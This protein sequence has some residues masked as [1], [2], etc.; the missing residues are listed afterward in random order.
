MGVDQR[1]MYFDPKIQGLYSLL[2]LDEVDDQPDRGFMYYRESGL[3]IV[4]YGPSGV[5]KTILALQMAVAARDAGY[6]VLYFTKDTPGSV[7]AI[8]LMEVFRFFGSTAKDKDRCFLFRSPGVDKPFSIPDAPY[9][10]VLT[11]KQIVDDGRPLPIDEGFLAFADFDA[12]GGVSSWADRYQNTSSPFDAIGH[13]QPS[14]RSLFDKLQEAEE[15]ASKKPSYRGLFVVCDS[16]RP[17][18]IE[19]HLRYQPQFRPADSGQASPSGQPQGAGVFLFVMEGAEMPP[20]LTVAYPPDIQIRMAFRDEHHGIRSRVLQLMKTR[21]QKSLDEETPFILLGALEAG[22]YAS[23]RTIRFPGSSSKAKVRIE[24]KDDARG[25]GV[26]VMPPVAQE[27]T[28]RGSGDGHCQP[29]DSLHRVVRFGVEGVDG[30]THEGNL[31][32]GGCTLLVTQNRCG[33]TVLGLHYLLAQIADARQHKDLV[34][35]SVLYISLAG[36]IDHVLHTVWRHPRLRQALDESARNTPW[37]DLDE[38]LQQEIL[39]DGAQEGV[40]HCDR[41]YRIPLSHVDIVREQAKRP[42]LRKTADCQPHFSVYV[43][44]FRWVTPEE[45]L[46]GLA[47]L[48]RNPRGENEEVP[49]RGCRRIDRVVLDRVGRLQSRWPLVKDHEVFVS[50][51]ASL[52]R[53]SHA[54]LMI[55]DDTVEITALSGIFKSRWAGVAQNIVQLRRTSFQGTEAMTIELVR[56]AGRVSVARRPHETVFVSSDEDPTNSSMR[57]EDNFR[58]YTALFTGEPRRC[59]LLVELSYD[60][61]STPLYHELLGAKQNIEASTDDVEVRLM[62]SGEWSGINSAYH[63]LSAASRDAC[64]IVAIDCV[65]IE[66]LIEAKV[67]HPFEPDELCKVLP[68]HIR[69]GVAA[70][71]LGG[72]PDS[73]RRPTSGGTKVP[74]RWRGLG[75]DPKFRKRLTE[76][77]C[78]TLEAICAHIKANPGT[79]WEQELKHPAAGITSDDIAEIEKAAVTMADAKSRG[80][81]F[82]NQ[83]VTQSL[84]VALTSRKPRNQT[85]VYDELRYAIP[86]R[87][88][89]GVLAVSRPDPERMEH[90]LRKICDALEGKKGADSQKK[91]NHPVVDRLTG[92]LASDSSHMPQPRPEV[93]HAV[94]GLLTR[95]PKPPRQSEKVWNALWGDETESSPITWKDLAAFRIECWH[96]F[97]KGGW[98]EHALSSMAASTGEAADLWTVL[99][100]RIDFFGLATGLPESSVSFF[101]ELLMAEAP[102]LDV[103]TR[104]PR[105]SASAKGDLPPLYVFLD[106]ERSKAAVARVV[107]L[108]CALLSK[109]QRRQIAIGPMSGH[110]HIGPIRAQ[111]LMGAAEPSHSPFADWPAQIAL[112]S[113][114]WLSTV[115]DLLPRYDIR[116][117]IHLRHLPSGAGA[118]SY[119]K[120]IGLGDTPPV[121]PTV[122]GPWYLGILRGGNADLG[123]DVMKD[124]LAPEHEVW[125]SFSGSAGPVSK[126]YYLGNGGDGTRTGGRHLPYMQ[127]IKDA[128][129]RQSVFP[130]DRN[131]IVSFLEVTPILYDLIR[132]VMSIEVSNE[133]EYSRYLRVEPFKKTDQLANQVLPIVRTALSRIAQVQGTASRPRGE[134]R[135]SRSREPG[136]PRKESDWKS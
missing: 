93:I 113:R 54:E 83:Y 31:A 116:H 132:R 58:G 118:A 55:I 80:R 85:D 106:D 112:F 76:K 35:R 92:W 41:H 88:N 60:D 129:V 73:P 136:V 26:T 127:R 47:R 15:N 91:D 17:E 79:T 49:C 67:L 20:T 52:C 82:K 72:T 43:P 42:L 86:M 9:C 38:E 105:E 75:R 100:P 125:S 101:L 13:L 126:E 74:T 68:S 107:L 90:V 37:K 94:V 128:A 34:P 122:G 19:E 56:A 115:P 14:L 39:R 70:E 87:H 6:H 12:M 89:W 64:H 78:N 110:H 36:E 135:H 45:A 50:G 134:S 99:F 63:D 65:W 57:I 1:K 61:K 8:R 120:E 33:S 133:Q 59:K 124:I 22:K 11:E 30:F 123:T 16:L 62:G 10:Q 53:Q 69:R 71:L 104:S 2:A 4:V 114:E 130:F 3:N 103:F 51:L 96:P 117:A 111:R 25:P 28:V 44:A 32:G 97:W 5:G 102:F 66:N 109:T 18:I 40:P 131:Q 46:D 27:T 23:Q 121:G 48:L 95:Q 119:W 29:E 84:T 98:V 21:F 81:A 77:D 108:F 7:L 24:S